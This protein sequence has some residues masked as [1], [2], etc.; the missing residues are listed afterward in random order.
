MMVSATLEGWS[1]RKSTLRG[2]SRRVYKESRTF[3][4]RFQ[5]CCRLSKWKTT[6]CREE[7]DVQFLSLTSCIVVVIGFIEINSTMK[8]KIWI[9]RKSLLTETF[10][11]SAHVL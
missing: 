8:A 6:R 2:F 4:E 7:E 1:S 9:L 11:F 10:F 5:L 3:K